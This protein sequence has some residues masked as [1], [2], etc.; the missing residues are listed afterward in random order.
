MHGSSRPPDLFSS[1]AAYRQAFEEG[2]VRLLEQGGLNL[3]I[4]VTANAGFEQ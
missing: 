2:L 3:F 1:P 4:L